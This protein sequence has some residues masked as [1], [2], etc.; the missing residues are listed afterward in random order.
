MT[1]VSVDETETAMRRPPR[2]KTEKAKRLFDQLVAELEADT[3]ADREQVALA[4]RY[5]LKSDDLLANDRLTAANEAGRRADAML[6]QLRRRRTA[7]QQQGMRSSSTCG[8]TVC[9]IDEEAA[10]ANGTTTTRPHEPD[11]TGA[12]WWIGGPADPRTTA[13]YDRMRRPA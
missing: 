1:G 13:F 11:A 2:L 4:V 8:L 10:W 7:P 3:I 5:R 9:G 6:G 12:P